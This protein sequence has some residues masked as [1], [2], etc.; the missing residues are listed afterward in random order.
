MGFFKW[1][2]NSAKMKRWMLIILIGIVLACIGISKIMVSKTVSFTEIGT[3]V[4]L[5][6][7]G[8]NDNYRSCI[9]SKKS[10]GDI[11]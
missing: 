10:L 5:F 1:F 2:K 7:V 3:V 8:F 6:V 11:S 4:A 9:F